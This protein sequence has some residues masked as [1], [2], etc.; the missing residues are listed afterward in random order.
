MRLNPWISTEF[1]LVST[2]APPSI[3]THVLPVP[4]QMCQ[5]H[6]L[7]PKRAERVNKLR[8]RVA[9][10]DLGQARIHLEKDRLR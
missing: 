7:I 10:L 1:S 9:V 4:R 8:E 6:H 2:P 3:S 5:L